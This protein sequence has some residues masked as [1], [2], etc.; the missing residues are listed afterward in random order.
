MSAEV[1][2]SL[3]PGWLLR[4]FMDFGVGHTNHDALDADGA[5]RRRLGGAGLGVSDVLPGGVLADASI[6]LPI[7]GR[8]PTSDGSRD[9]RLWV[10]FSKHF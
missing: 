3:A 7:N 5:N 6:A 9:A 8:H 4:G 10:Q 1:R 2:E